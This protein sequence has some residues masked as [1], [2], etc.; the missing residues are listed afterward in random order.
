MA[1]SQLLAALNR[2]DETPGATAW[3]TLRTLDGN[4]QPVD[5]P[6]PTSALR[7]ASNL[8]IQDLCPGRHVD[9]LSMAFDK[10]VHAALRDAMTHR[11]P[12]RSKRLAD[13]TLCATPFVGNFPTDERLRQL[14]A[15]N[16]H[17]ITQIV[18][19]PTLTSEPPLTLEP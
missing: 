17:I 1:T 2:H 9:H 13:A 4:A 12:A 11:E 7:G 14:E 5:G 16:V 10:L 6:D 8:V 18:A 19:A 15:L 3:T